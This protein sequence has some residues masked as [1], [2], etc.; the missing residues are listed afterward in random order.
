MDFNFLSFRSIFNQQI[1]LKSFS[2]NC[3]KTSTMKTRNFRLL[4]IFLIYWNFIQ[5]NE[6]DILSVRVNLLT[7]NIQ[8]DGKFSAEVN[9]HISDN[10]HINSHKP[11]D[12]FLIP[13]ELRIAPSAEYKI[14]RII[15]P[16]PIIKRLAFSE[17]P[18]SIFEGDFGI[19]IEGKILKNADSSVTL[20][21]SL[22]YQ[23]CN[24]QVCLPPAEVPFVLEIPVRP[25]SINSADS[26]PTDFP[27]TSQTTI[28]NP[29]KGFDIGN[30]L[31]EKGYFLTFILIFLGGL[32]LNLTPCIYPLI[33]VTL[34]YFGGQAVGKKNKTLLLAL[35]YVL[36]M[37]LVNSLLGTLAALSGSLLGSVMT[38]PIVLIV[39]AVILV[40]LALSMFGLYEIG[41]PNSL[42]KLAGGSRSGYLGALFMGLTMGIVAAPC[43]GPFV[44]GLLTYV[45][46]IGKPFIGFLMFFTLS[47]GLGLPFIVLAFFAAQ[48]DRLPRSG[49]WM[50]GIRQIFGFLLIGMALYFIK[51][52]LPAG[53]A[54]II[55]W[56]YVIAS[57]IY[58][59]LFSKSGNNVRTFVFIKN[60]LAIVAI[61][62][63]TWFLK[64]EKAERIE[65]Q[66]QTYSP[67]DFD[68][69][70]EEKRPILLDFY[71]DW[72]IPCKEL[73]QYT[74]SNPEIVRLSQNFAL[75]KIDLTGN[76]TPEIQTLVEKY[77]I[78]GVPTI[79]FINRDGR[80]IEDLRLLGFE[81]A[82]SFIR[83]MNQ[84]LE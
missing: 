54:S 17:Q 3:S 52:L 48:L 74:F 53:L 34:S 35:L 16:K 42:M 81:N 30:S 84:A 21:G 58:L 1:T 31:A 40:T 69:A 65:I 18:L 66:W 61:I 77:D 67:Q 70:L 46:S 45:A 60:L 22:Y 43:I 28:S 71:A 19:Q 68:L 25:I 62:S 37:A 79:I 29:E 13:T 4:A 33:P 11:N 80:E 82:D 78:K 41:V 14:S 75:F 64:S 39:I 44:I 55:I 59:I 20:K 10:W 73:D 57:G 56:L 47:L 63:G 12:E 36:G 76:V 2:A 72:C 27:Q 8:N 38:N 32:G 51:P 23:G 5:A 6:S 7:P 49:E 24:D 50:V 26:T 15:F 9:V 83:R